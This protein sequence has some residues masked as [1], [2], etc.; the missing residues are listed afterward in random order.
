ML[1]TIAQEDSPRFRFQERPWFREAGSAGQGCMCREN[2]CLG[3]SGVTEVRLWFRG[4]L[5]SLW[6]L[7]DRVSTSCQPTP[8]AAELFSSAKHGRA[9]H[10]RDGYRCQNMCQEQ[11]RKANLTFIRQMALI[12]TNVD[13][14]T[15]RTGILIVGT[16]EA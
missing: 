11:L 1:A 12:P 6:D 4:S 7:G 3:A 2:D 9:R 10:P 13:C 14:C 16:H 15:V 5:A 8:W